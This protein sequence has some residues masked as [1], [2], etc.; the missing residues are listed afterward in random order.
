MAFMRKVLTRVSED[1]L[2]ALIQERLAPGADEVAIDVTIQSGADFCSMTWWRP[3]R[4][5]SCPMN[6][7]WMRCARHATRTFH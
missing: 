3:K 6:R 5:Q 1:R 7:R 2:E 4:K